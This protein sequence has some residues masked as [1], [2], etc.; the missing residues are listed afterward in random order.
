M[1]EPINVHYQN[2]RSRSQ[3]MSEQTFAYGVT[4]AALETCQCFTG[5]L[6]QHLW[7]GDRERVWFLLDLFI[8]LAVAANAGYL[9]FYLVDLFKFF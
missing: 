3:S 8:V 1:G 6:L 2:L 9:A 5:Q 7:I 4:F